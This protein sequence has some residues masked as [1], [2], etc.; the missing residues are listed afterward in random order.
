MRKIVFSL[1][2]FLQVQG[3]SQTIPA[4]RPPRSV[5]EPLPA[6]MTY[7]EFTK[8]Q[9]RLNWKRLFAAS[10]IPGYIHFYAGYKKYAWSIAGVRAVGFG[11]ISYSLLDELDHTDSFSLSF[12]GA[13]DSVSA[14]KNRS[15]RN[16]Y[17]F[18][19]GIALNMIGYAFDWA[20]GD[21]IIEQERNAVLYKFGRLKAAGFWYDAPRRAFGPVLHFPL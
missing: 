12:S 11:M 15:R 21:F 6:G 14:Y 7:L 1:L 20:H 18:L 9:R 16:L 19:G 10:F 4:S 3:F 8:L 17:L 2:I 13:A 5:F